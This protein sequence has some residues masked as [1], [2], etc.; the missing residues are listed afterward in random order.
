[1]IRANHLSRLTTRMEDATKTLWS[2]TCRACG[3][4]WVQIVHPTVNVRAACGACDSTD[5]EWHGP[6]ED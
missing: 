5:I 2:A 6:F 3:H 4:Y 1:M